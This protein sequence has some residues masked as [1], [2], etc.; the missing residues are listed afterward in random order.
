MSFI[1]KRAF[2][3]IVAL[4]TLLLVSPILIVVILIIKLE[5]S[6]PVFFLQKRL[7]YRGKIFELYK[8]RSMI[9]KERDLTIQ[10]TGAES[11]ITRIGRIIR[12]FKIDE[13]PQ[14]I[15]VLKGDM[16]IVGPR[17]CLPELKDSFNSDGWIR[18]KVRP[19][20]TGLA[21]IS[22][23]IHLSWEERWS[24][25]RKYVENSS[26]LLDLK[27]IALTFLIVLFGDKWGLGR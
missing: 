19:G 17:P 6:G 15:N 24:L 4:A 10:T 5:S 3:F 22:G 26:L 1:V 12:R 11:D 25:D 20:L 21:Q 18:I 14:L 16:S 2:D 27:I 13:L 8:L 7:G 9:N 23:N